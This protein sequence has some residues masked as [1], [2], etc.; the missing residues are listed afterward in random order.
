MYEQTIEP[1][2]PEQPS[3]EQFAAD[4]GL[5]LAGGFG[6]Y[7][8]G[9]N[10]L[11]S[12]TLGVTGVPTFSYTTNIIGDPW[13][14]TATVVNEYTVLSIPAF[15]RGIR[16]LA[17]T[18]AGLP[19]DVC[20]H[21]P[22]GTR[23]RLDDHPLD[24]VLNDEINDLQTPFDTK[25]ILYSHAIVWGNGYCY[26]D[27]TGGQT[28]L[29]NL[30]PDRV[31]PFRFIGP[32]GE[33]KQYYSIGTA[34]STGGMHVVPA[35]DILHI[36]GL[37]FDGL[38]GYPIVQI[39]SQPLRVGKAA[40]AFGDRFF[41][42]GGHLGGVIESPEKLTPEQVETLRTQ[43]ATGYTGVA[44][45]HRWMILMN[46][47]TA[48]TLTMPPETAQYLETRQMAV[49]DVSRILGIPPHILFEL[50]R[51]TWGNIEQ[52]GI[53]LVKYSL[54]PW[55]IKSEQEYSRKLLTTQ[56]RKARLYVRL[57][58]DALQRGDHA[59]QIDSTSKRIASGLTSI[60]EERA[61]YDLPGIG[62]DGDNHYVP[63]NWQNTAKAAAGPEETTPEAEP[64]DTTTPQAS[65]DYAANQVKPSPI[66]IEHFA[67][68]LASAE[69][70]VGSKT[71]KATDNARQKFLNTEP[72]QMTSWTAWGNVFADEQ[73]KYSVEAVQPILMTYASVSG[74]QL[75]PEQTASKIGN[76]Y[77]FE[78][79]RYYSQ[80]A[81][82]EEST[83]PDLAAIVRAFIQGDYGTIDV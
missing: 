5:A 46:K 37:G 61:L 36:A 65:Q 69:K 68:L 11:G 45:S 56:E 71:S 60:N 67:G 12:N 74:H 33:P 8:G 50:G 78:L 26:I 3:R 18:L 20:Q 43:I 57:N 70:R 83:P 9:S 2:R 81:Q 35:T 82:G 16:F 77:G 1:Q 42:N 64:E 80:L 6:G 51:A 58:V 62:P 24:W 4:G 73:A 13:P 25:A 79:R 28:R 75:D 27:R 52:M 39:M 44:N 66:T 53:E 55:V 29:W 34:A 7:E 49:I 30:L 48:K 14:I 19:A 40:E 59:Q 31:I 17:E 41:S 32:D 15:W 38:R 63:A 21:L 47:A 76:K 23:Q 54:G 10:L 72:K 22:K